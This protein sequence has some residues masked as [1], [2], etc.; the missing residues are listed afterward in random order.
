MKQESQENQL[1]VVD[2]LVSLGALDLP[3]SDLYLDRARA[4][5]GQVLAEEQYRTLR[6]ERDSLP[7]LAK[8]LRREAERGDWTKVRALAQRGAHDRQRIADSQRLVALGDAVYGPRGFHADAS[9]LALSGMIV[10]PTS[11]LGHARDE[12]V[13]RLRFLIGN[14]REQ[15]E[16]YR[17]RLAHFE[18]LEVVAD[19]SLGTVVNAADLQHRILEAAD[20]GDFDQAERLTAAILDATP[21]SRLGRIRA[22]RPDASLVQALVAELPEV[23]VRRARDL[24]LS[25]VTLTADDALNGYLSCGC[26]ERMTFPDAPLT[27]AHRAADTC[28][29]G[30]ACPPAVSDGLREVLDLLMLHPFVTSAGSR[31]LPWFGPERLLVETFPETEPETRTGLLDA[32][33][34]QSRRSVSRLAIDD[35]VRSHSGRLCTDLGLDPAAHAV[36][37]IPFDAYLRLAPQFG[38]GRQHRWT[39]FDGYQVTRELHLRGLVGGDA[40]YGGPE[41]MCSVARDYETER[42]LARFVIVRRDRF[43]AREPVTS[44]S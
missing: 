13:D 33:G 4:L 10:Q 9:A 18:G 24:G 19:E 43:A 35:A 42:L 32:L 17:A 44:P 8:E 5:L 36:V 28:T 1:A 22:P 12:C 34:L 27:E 20:R 15:A 2:A 16:Y 37:P 3:C 11:H 39:H 7:S 41:D 21:E 14:D 40:T 29:C 26:V 25:A 38:W 6:R 30:H 23:A 31:Y